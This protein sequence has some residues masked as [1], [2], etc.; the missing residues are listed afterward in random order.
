MVVFQ[1]DQAGCRDALDSARAIIIG[2]DDLNL[3]FKHP[4]RNVRGAFIRLQV[5]IGIAA[6]ECG[7][8]EKDSADVV[9]RP[10]DLASR[11]SHEAEVDQVMVAGE[12]LPLAGLPQDGFEPA[13][14][15][16]VLKGIPL[17]EPGA[18]EV[19][20]Y[21]KIPRLVNHLLPETFPSGMLRVYTSRAELD[22]EFGVLNLLERAEAGSEIL[23]VGR[24]LVTWAN[25]PP[26]AR[27]AI[28]R[29][30]LQLKLLVSSEAACRSMEDESVAVI[31]KHKRA[32][33]PFFRKLVNSPHIWAK[34]RET[35]F[36][37]PDGF[38]CA[39]VNVGET[40]KD[41]VLRDINSGP[42]TNKVTI[43]FA[44]TCDND[45]SRRGQ[46]ITCGM[47]E[48]GT[49]LFEKFARDVF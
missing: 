15:R 1:G 10:A 35:E 16:L 13:R 9:G 38:T 39:R 24:T 32:A 20:Y 44:C 7:A 36:L 25:M 48:R 22:Q 3:S 46:C 42:K 29:K 6:G 14:R 26:A 11:L 23:V 33:L 45:T 47:R 41:I 5:R 2:V 40:V 37:M 12:I 27:K 19:F 21:L 49:K 4:S 34:F 17:P 31:A 43:L 18:A 8:I 28:Q 30:R